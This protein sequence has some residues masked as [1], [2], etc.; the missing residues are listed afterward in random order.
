VSSAYAAALV[1]RRVQGRAIAVAASGA[2]LGYVLGVPLVTA[3]GGALDWRAA[4]GALALGG[5]VVALV[6]GGL[7]PAVPTADAPPERLTVRATGPLVAVA[8]ATSAAFAGHYALYTFVSPLLIGA[9]VPEQALGAL[10]FLLGAAGV[11][12]L[13]LAGLVIDRRPRLGFLAALGL[14]VCFVASLGITR[15]STAGAITATVAW[16]VAF[17]AIPTFCTAA[18]LRTRVVT[19]DLAA[20]V[21]NASA[22]VGIGG[23][24]ALG[25]A[26]W[27][28]GGP[29]G[30]VTLGAAG[31]AVAFG[32]VIA[33]RRGF[34]ARPPA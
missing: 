11:I 20:A 16:L 29:V 33:L 23:G 10:L 12:G 17:G 8:V 13:W 5:A 4:F 22:N 27:A 2:S 25:A 3:I 21:N 1:P 6:T 14:A 7:L 19:P 31:F 18:A 9:G 34:P 26:A 28:A 15:A 32:L 24:A 30:V